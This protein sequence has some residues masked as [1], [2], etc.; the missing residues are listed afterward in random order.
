[1]KEIWYSSE[2]KAFL[3]D[4]A[5]AHSESICLKCESKGFC[6]ACMA[7]NFHLTGELFDPHESVCLWAKMAG[8]VYHAI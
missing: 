6:N 7:D 8:K 3:T 1:M 4:C 5:G 2:L